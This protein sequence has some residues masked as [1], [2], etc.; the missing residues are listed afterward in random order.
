MI[1]AKKYMRRGE[2]CLRNSDVKLRI[3]NRSWTVQFRIYL[4]RSC[5]FSSGWF[6]FARE[7]CLRKGDVCVF[8]LT[9]RDDLEFEVSIIRDLN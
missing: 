2:R 9:N 8:E 5:K 3:S 7:N 4:S 1:F 6:A